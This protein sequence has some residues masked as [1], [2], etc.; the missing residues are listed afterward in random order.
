MMMADSLQLTAFGM[1][2]KMRDA[3]IVEDAG[4][5]GDQG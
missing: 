1:S 2:K 3:R 4:R 5:K